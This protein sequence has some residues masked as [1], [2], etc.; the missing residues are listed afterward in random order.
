MRYHVLATDY[1]GTLAKD[2]RVAPDIIESLKRFKSSGR[3]LILVTGRELEDMQKLFPEHTLFDLIVA[4]NG[5]LI[6]H[7]A[8]LEERL[9][10]ERPPEAFIQKLKDQNVQPLSVGRV[11]VATWEPHQGTVLI[12]IKE[13]GLE[14]QIIFN[15][16]AVMILPPGINK[17]KGL[18]EALKELG[19]S[20]HNTVAIGD[21]END[22]AMLQV[23]ECAVAV[24]NALPQVK[25]IADWTT[26]N[27]HG[28]GVTELI[29]QIIKDDLI[30]L[31]KNLSRHHLELGQSFDGSV[32]G[33][34]PYGNSLLLAGT[35]GS[36][37][38]TF[39]A[40]FLE[41]LMAKQYQFCLIDPEGDYL[42]LA[43]VITIGDTN[44]PPVI[45]QVIKLL[46]KAI[47]NT[48][49][50]ILAIP[51]GDRPAFFNKLLAAVI[52]LRKDT[53]HPHFIIMEEA[54]HLVPKEAA[55]SSF[56]FPEDFKNFF[57]ITTKPDLISHTFLERVNIAIMMG[58]SPDQFMAEFASLVHLELDIPENIVLQKGEALVWQK[59]QHKILPFRC[60]MPSQYLHRHKRKYATG[61]MGSNS[62]YFKGPANKLNLK[63]NN[64]MTFVQMGTG[65]DDDTW[66]YHLLQKDFSKWFRESVNDEELAMRTEKIEE[67]E[68]NAAVSRKAIF[69]LIH[70]LYTAPA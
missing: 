15:K 61:D 20:E 60:S 22:N 36:G 30:R 11:I 6:Y 25:T 5:A 31:D 54:H 64:L 57:V 59:D 10:G 23:T 39:V 21:A 43:G 53:G 44:Q 27:H 63:A 28:E 67:Q 40:A 68:R 41:K 66:Q 16:G 1:D 50:C 65:I 45:E 52:E 35:S 9:L 17:S 46:T 34:S 51:L 32:F 47:Q 37:K 62:F 69:H 24:Q 48:V 55:D 4:E 42:D 29:D 33:I 49:V 56:N 26:T 12:A 7:P 70:E 2:E 58:Q 18:H 14:Y 13:I 19:I 38:T 3:K 8:T